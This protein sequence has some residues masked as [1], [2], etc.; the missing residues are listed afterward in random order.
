[1][2]KKPLYMCITKISLRNTII[3]YVKAHYPHNTWVRGSKVSFDRHFNACFNLT[4]DQIEILVLWIQYIW[5]DY[6]CNNCSVQHLLWTLTHLKTY[7]TYENVQCIIRKYK[8]TL[9]Q[10]VLYTVDVIAEID[11]VSSVHKIFC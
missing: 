3:Y 1:M 10:W 11:M 7:P 8:K 2:R 4:L 9:K 6:I 5:G